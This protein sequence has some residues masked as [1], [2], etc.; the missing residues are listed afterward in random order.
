MPQTL[1]QDQAQPVAVDAVAPVADAGEARSTK[2]ILML[3]PHP[4]EID[5]R[6]DWVEDLCREL[7]WTEIIA[8]TH[9]PG[10]KPA[11]RYDGRVF[12]EELAPKCERL[13][14]FARRSVV[15]RARAIARR[16]I[17][18]PAITPIAP[19]ATD[20]ARAQGALNTRA[21]ATAA[22][23]GSIRA[24]HEAGDGAPL[25]RHR[26]KAAVPPQIR[27]AIP[28]GVKSSMRTVYWGSRS[29]LLRQYRFLQ[30][31]PARLRSLPWRMRAFAWRVRIRLHSVVRHV[32]TAPTRSSQ[33][34][35]FRP[36]SVLLK[37]RAY[38]S[39]A[40]TLHRRCRSISIPPDVI[41]CHDI[42]ALMTA[43]RLKRQFGC[44]VI[45]DAHEYWPEADLLAP[46]WESWLVAK[47]EGRYIR[48]A[49]KVVTVTPQLA[50][51][52][53]RKYEIR[54]V[55]CVPNAEPWTAPRRDF[56][57]VRREGPVRFL[58]QGRVV[59]GRAVGRFLDA[60]QTIAP[61]NA[62]LIL[63]SPD[64][65]YLQQLI[66][67]FAEAIER[68]LIVLAPPVTE[69]ELVSEAAKA[70]VGVITYSGPSLNHI[71]C[72]PNK[73][74]QYM[75]AGLAIFHHQ[76]AQYVGDVVNASGGGLSF[77]PDD[78]EAFRRSIERMTDREFLNTSR[79]NA[80]IYARDEFNWHAQLQP[81]RRA[82]EDL[83]SQPAPKP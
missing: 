56:P 40:R 47:I 65:P 28:A 21:H 77:D 63:R 5:P 76:D 78:I 37:W 82:I 62:V 14:C 66:E 58:I 31:T 34:S 17:K 51:Q 29:A 80:F 7:A 73:L 59:P 43:I 30:S 48:H 53:E 49:D 8:F 25:L 20:Y 4:L 45:Y 71:Y 39:I 10:L 38:R 55:L 70:D 12:A 60:W 52:L 35:L 24:M 11:R 23:N 26:M 32:A 6:V 46:K 2:R 54:D 75:Q 27:Q 67:R 64:S 33:A 22:L 9:A 72:C 1:E 50:R 41:V 61:Q 3:V 44:P 36:L 13:P 15:Q 69:Q 42:I 57:E 19:A 16:V 83:L 74:S 79:Q 81:Y 18:G 68:G